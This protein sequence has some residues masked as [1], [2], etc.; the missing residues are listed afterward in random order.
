M[1]QSFP[2]KSVW[3]TAGGNGAGIKPYR[4]FTLIELIIVITIVVILAGLF[5]ARIPSYQ[6]RA[7]KAAMEQVVGALQSALLLRYGSLMT[8]GATSGKELS[9]LTSDNPM[10]WLQ[11]KPQNYAGEYYDPGP[12]AV[13]PGNWM[14]DLKTHDLIYVLDRNDSF[15]PGKDGKKWIRFHIQLGYEPSLG[16]AESGRELATT[17][18]VPVEPY[19][20]LE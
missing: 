13:A 3:L 12:A 18:F 11:Q 9:N 8:R 19:H 1:S 5:M 17:L 10:N 7:E 2:R 16:R 14:F 4:G 6:E 15:S 20:W